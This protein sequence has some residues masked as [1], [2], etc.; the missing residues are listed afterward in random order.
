MSIDR[1]S[2]AGTSTKS[3]K[4]TPALVMATSEIER[5]IREA[6]ENVGIIEQATLCLV[7][8]RPQAAPDKPDAPAPN[9][10]THEQ[11]L[12]ILYAGVALLNEWFRSIIDEL[13]HAV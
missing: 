12:A 5:L 11:T 4:D 3:L 6:H 9:P 13:N 2:G 7:N 1:L 8:S 10:T